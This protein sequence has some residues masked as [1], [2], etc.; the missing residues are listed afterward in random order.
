MDTIK[1]RQMPVQ[2]HADRFTEIMDTI[3]SVAPWA[4]CTIMF[5]KLV[6]FIA[7]YLED[8]RKDRVVDIVEPLLKQQSDIFNGKISELNHSVNELNKSIGGLANQIKSSNI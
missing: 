6:N 8:T 2:E 1:I 4:S 7:Q 3:K 5:W